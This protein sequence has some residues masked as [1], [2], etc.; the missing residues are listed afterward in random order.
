MFTKNVKLNRKEIG[1]IYQ[2]KNKT[3]R[4]KKGKQGI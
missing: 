3:K 4:A 1:R 2:S